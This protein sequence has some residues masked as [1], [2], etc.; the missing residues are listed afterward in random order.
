MAI[1]SL[2]DHSKIYFKIYN[3]NS[4][5]L[6]FVESLLH[7]S[8]SSSLKFDGSEVSLADYIYTVLLQFPG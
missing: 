3:N 8:L 2:Q 4:L 1:F 5:S 7:S 6:F